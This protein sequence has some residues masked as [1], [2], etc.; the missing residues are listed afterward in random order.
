MDLHEEFVT[1]G[2]SDRELT[3]ATALKAAGYRTA[4]IGKWHLGDYSRKAGI[5]PH[6]LRLRPLP[7]VPHSNDMRPCPLYRNEQRIADDV[8]D[9]LPRS[10]RAIRRRGERH[11]GGHAGS[12]S[13]LLPRPH[14][15][16]PAALAAS[17]RFAAARGGNGGDAVEEIDWSDRRDPRRAGTRRR[18][19]AHAAGVHQRQRSVVRG[20][21]RRAARRQGPGLRRR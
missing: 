5:P 9:I 2:L 20:Q 17:A 8:L 7:G 14:V 1:E 11:R 18:R 12:P 10:R 16:A 4:M 21:R 6:A 15:P 3:L 13:S 19:R